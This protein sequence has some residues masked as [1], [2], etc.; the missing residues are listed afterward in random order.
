M[1][2]PVSEYVNL[3]TQLLTLERDYDDAQLLQ[4]TKNPIKLNNLQAS[5]H[6]ITCLS[7]NSVT[8]DLGGRQVLRFLPNVPQR[9]ISAE[10]ISSGDNV[11]VYPQ[12]IQFP[13][14]N[15]PHAVVDVLNDSCVQ[16]ICDSPFPD[17]ILDDSQNVAF[18]IIKVSSHVTYDRYVS[19]LSMLP[20]VTNDVTHPAHPLINAILGSGKLKFQLPG[21]DSP[22][23]QLNQ[24]QT[25]SIDAAL[26]ASHLS[27]IHGPPGTGKTHTLVEYILK[28]VQRGSRLLVVA[29]SNI[30]VDNIAERLASPMFAEIKFVRVGH[31]ARII[32]SVYPHTLEGLVLASDEAKLADDIRCELNA[33]HSKHSHKGS[34][35]MDRHALRHERIELRKE[36]RRRENEAT[37]RVLSNADVVLT[38]ISGV[39]A[40][41]LKEKRTGN[42]PVFDV[43]IID[44][45]AQALEATVW[46]PFLRAKKAVLA[47]DPWQLAGTVKSA[48][49]ERGGLQRSILDR[50]FESERLKECVTTLT[51]QYRMN[52]I[53]CGWSSAEFYGGQ[54][55][56]DESVADRLLTDTKMRKTDDD[57]DELGVSYG[58]V[59]IDTTGG[60]CEEENEDEKDDS[61]TR[62]DKGGRSDGSRRN[63]GEAAILQRVIGELT[64]GGVEASDIGV[65]SPYAGQVGLLRKY[66]WDQY[67]HNLEVA[68]VDSFQGREKEVICISLVRS[69]EES[70][71][72]FLADARRM[73]VAMTRAKSLLVVVCDSETVST[74]PVME[75]MISYAE[76]HGLY[77]SAVVEFTDI[78]G[79]FSQ[80]RRPKEAIVA[81]KLRS[82]LT[83]S[84]G[85]GVGQS[86]N[87]S[88]RNDG[89]GRIT[90]RDEEKQVDGERQL[91]DEE[92]L[93]NWVVEEVR[94]FVENE[95]VIEKRFSSDLSAFGRRL[96]HEV[97]EKM[98]VQHGSC[99]TGA[100]RQVRVWK[101][102]TLE[103]VSGRVERIGFDVL[104]DEVQGGGEENVEQDAD[105]IDRSRDE[106]E[107]NLRC[108]QEERGKISDP[109]EGNALLAELRQAREDRQREGGGHGRADSRTQG[110]GRGQ[111]RGRG[112]GRDGLRR[113]SRQTRGDEDSRQP[114]GLV[115]G[116]VIVQGVV[117]NNS[118]ERSL[119]AREEAKKRL[120][121]KV[122]EQADQ[123]RRRGASR[124]G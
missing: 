29:P 69:N 79:T 71:I 49:A 31:P 16:V 92:N 13:L 24:Q 97:A 12:T 70:E 45:A 62:V 6:A 118:N 63:E 50:I 3:Q 109:P 81:E 119:R 86:S 75:R 68:T 11:V 37:S 101:E 52:N 30:A 102:G 20:Q 73:N 107:T 72:G 59:L 89:G 78:V 98:G 5:G 4:S 17:D 38:T 88:K 65:I 95:L 84:N 27:V 44:E 21:L 40:S 58:L 23:G 61:K 25:V 110:R 82:K 116:G 28:E 105:N 74:N 43:V 2:F 33:L 85:L 96:V 26:R 111:S 99:D 10:N 19:A 47:G 53:I 93:R 113:E 39:G 34:G 114:R 112:R 104:V 121:A 55:Q 8:S 87:F 18:T 66:L 108:E 9:R 15:S 48:E 100:G 7:L 67:G 64:K 115:V 83:L 122:R 51:V 77:R 94:K 35:I 60:D 103:G 46:A 14:E 36:L 41:V 1:S 32:P 22:I 54:L 76:T 117:R 120:K 90:R 80:L 123:R 124:T 56:A 91:E 57:E 106:T 42:G